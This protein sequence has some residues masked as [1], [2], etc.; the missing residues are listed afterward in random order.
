MQVTRSFAR[1]F[2]YED[3]FRREGARKIWG[4]SSQLVLCAHQAVLHIV[5][6]WL[7]D[8][9]KEEGLTGSEGPLAVR[10]YMT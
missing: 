8:V 5:V 3:W 1:L 6:K 7:R 4:Q 9:A 2:V 10:P